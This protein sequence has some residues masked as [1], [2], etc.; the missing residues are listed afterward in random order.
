TK[1]NSKDLEMPSF[2]S[3]GM[4]TGGGIKNGKLHSRSLKLPGIL[5]HLCAASLIPRMVAGTGWQAVRRWPC[6]AEP[7]V[8]RLVRAIGSE[9][10][11]LPSLSHTA[12]LDKAEAVRYDWFASASRCV[13]VFLESWLKHE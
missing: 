4:K 1:V 12:Y 5:T 7:I 13:R 9:D 6:W 8:R 3:Q 2:I 10:S 11:K